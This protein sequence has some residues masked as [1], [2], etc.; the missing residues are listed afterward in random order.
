M[1]NPA[2]ETAPVAP[3]QPAETQDAG[4]A[5]AMAK[6]AEIRKPAAEKPP[7]PAAPEPAVE[8]SP[9]EPA[10]AQ[11]EVPAP[12][13]LPSE[14]LARQRREV[15]EADKLRREL[16][17]TRS[18]LTPLERLKSADPK[19]R[20]S[21]L[22][23]LG[24]DVAD[25]ALSSLDEAREEPTA[26]EQLAALKAE[27][28]ALKVER[29]KSEAR[30]QLDMYAQQAKA[31]IDSEPDRWALLRDEPRYEKE[32]LDVIAYEYKRT[33]REVSFEDA[34]DQLEHF[35]RKNVEAALQKASKLGMYNAAPATPATK[36]PATP[37]SPPA[38]P[39]AILSPSPTATIKVEED[40]WT[41]AQRALAAVRAQNK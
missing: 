3:A 19:E 17:A 18:Q 34:A 1:S 5:L 22:Q 13:E 38:A 10:Q 7:E 33:G 9:E 24:I 36:P 14:R 40:S 21:V 2:V 8:E 12:S 6:L 27:I 16:E 25:L 35:L 11:E 29:Q 41:R 32:V 15:R 31:V 20:L 30:R 39:P 4:F 26:D 28:D 37:Q 23:D